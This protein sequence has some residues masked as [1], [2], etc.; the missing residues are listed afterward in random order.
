MKVLSKLW[1]SQILRIA[2]LFVT[3]FL[4][5][6][7]LW[8][9]SL[10]GTKVDY[11]R[12]GTVGD[13][14]SG[15]ATMSAVIVAMVAFSEEK[16][17]SDAEFK[18]LE[19]EKEEQIVKERSTEHLRIREQVGAIYCWS[20]LEVDPVR[21]LT[22]GVNI[23]VQNGTPIPVYKWSMYLNVG[24][25]PIMTGANNGPLLPGR[26]VLRPTLGIAPESFAS[27][28]ALEIKFYAANGEWLLRDCNGTLSVWSG[29]LGQPEVSL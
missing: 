27:P 12:F 26:T 28:P 4:L 14:F 18:R 2:L 24:D 15:V 17:R 10:I 22:L 21:Q 29:P 13:W 19:R 6:I 25:A 9:L 1:Q 11:E 7:D 8:G 23:I 3:I 20:A 5:L 16:K